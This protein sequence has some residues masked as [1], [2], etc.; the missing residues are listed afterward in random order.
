MNDF[1]SE[2][3]PPELPS[4]R[5]PQLTDPFQDGPPPLP[6]NLQTGDALISPS[7]IDEPPPLP[8]SA[9]PIPVQA[10]RDLEEPVIEYEKPKVIPPRHVLLAL[11]GLLVLAGFV[12][13][14]MAFGEITAAAFMPLT[15]LKMPLWLLAVAK[16]FLA[17]M[18]V[19]LARKL[20]KGIELE[21][22]RYF[23]Q[24]AS[25]VSWAFFIVAVLGFIVSIWSQV[26]IVV[27]LVT[28]IDSG[29]AKLAEITGD[30]NEI[31]QTIVQSV[32]S[33]FE[34]ILDWYEGNDGLEPEPVE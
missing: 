26:P 31:L 18:V 10:A 4:H 11:P 22:F 34:T 5:P 19:S 8:A 12:L 14:L 24:F 27:H 13:T 6:F 30:S 21:A 25:R 9:S 20:S 1:R 17:L 32:K 16:T 3:L 15:T 28:L 33:V 2:E 29:L 7:I 23:A